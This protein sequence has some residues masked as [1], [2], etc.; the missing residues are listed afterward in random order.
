MAPPAS[1][2]VQAAG[3]MVTGADLPGRRGCARYM[4]MLDVQTVAVFGAGGK[5]GRRVVDVLGRRGIKVRALVHRT[6]VEGEHV[7]SI[8][9]SVTDPADVT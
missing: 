6:A 5:V 8:Q 1:P 7:T 2:C 3:F 9:G 4:V